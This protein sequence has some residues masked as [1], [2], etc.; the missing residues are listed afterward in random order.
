M[1]APHS[2]FVWPSAAK[3]PLELLPEE[4]R[5]LQ[6]S[7]VEMLLVNGTMDFSTPPTALDEARPYWHKAQMVLLPDFSHVE[8][9]YTLQQTA[10]EQLITSYLD[11]GVGD[12]SLYVYQPIPFKAGVSNTVVAK[13]LVALVIILPALIVLGI[14]ALVR[15]I[16]R[17]RGIAV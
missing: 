15:R 3:W 2:E 14:V 7:D 12:A 10:W 11:T 5:S 9:E 6:E 13:A 1:G 4:L 16:R 17:G 8:D